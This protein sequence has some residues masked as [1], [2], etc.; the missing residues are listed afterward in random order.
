MSLRCYFV[1][2]QEPN[3]DKNPMKKQ[4][5]LLLLLLSIL[6]SFGIYAQDTSL[7]EVLKE[8]DE[9]IGQKKMYHQQRASQIES[10]KKKLQHS[11]D[12]WEQYNIY[13]A[14]SSLYL[15]FQA[16]SA[17]YYVNRKASLLQQLN[18]PE[19]YNQIYL[20]RAEVFGLMGMY[21]EASEELKKVKVS[22]LEN[23]A[24][25]YYYRSYRVYYGWLADY[26]ADRSARQKYIDMTEAYRDSI[27]TLDTE[28]FDRKLIL[29]EK[30]LQNRNMDEAISLLNTLLE[31]QNDLQRKAYLYY[32][33]S[34]AYEMKKQV[35]RQAYYLAQSAI[36]DMKLANRE[37]AAL[38]RLANLVY[39]R[40][41]LSRAYLYLNCA[42]E[43][44]VDCNAR[45]RFMEVAAIY[46][47]IDKAYKEKDQ[48][49]K[50]VTRWMLA[51]L[52]LFVIILIV[53]SFYFYYWMKKLSLMRK[54]LYM[55]NRNLVT[56]NQELAQTG[57]IKEVYIAR[58]LDRCVSYLEKLEQYRRSLE[59]LAMASKIDELFKTIRSEQFLR[60]E[61][62]AFYTEFD[63]S[64]LD[65]FPNFIEDF[66]KLL[67]DDGKIYPKSGELL[68]T[69]LRIFAL[70]RL[71]VTDATRIAH[72]LGYSLAT[73]YNYR[74][75]IRN[76]AVGD[77][78]RFE[79][80]VMNL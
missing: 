12:S 51:I 54:N 59:K 3:D 44:A 1:R 37:Y 2:L 23:D 16:D 11:T 20:N 17:L 41:E 7:D 71:R 61:R 76:K 65:L 57:K 47:I 62:K 74:S 52:S 32:T 40:G 72:F 48:Q 78:D 56:A 9:A 75:K 28:N 26:T 36:C 30:E 34:E 80:E 19:L 13:G 14:L 58:Y 39:D 8:L 68:N 29:A 33:L 5:I 64:F 73:V 70:I 77:K 45:L 22:E 25:E 66:N 38:Q 49:E 43:D 4:R 55:A 27:L 60:D 50:A 6:S 15:H 53:L 42:M 10:L 79:Q 67:V 31:K 63:K 21:N 18:R 46:P 35:D 24:L 69:E